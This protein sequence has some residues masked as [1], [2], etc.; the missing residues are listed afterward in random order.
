MTARRASHAGIY[1]ILLKLYPADFRAHYSEQMVQLF[2]DQLRDEGAR[3]SWLTALMDIPSSAAS[4]HLR[5]SRK[6]AHSATLAPTPTSRILGILG[7]IGGLV[8][9][10][11]FV[12]D[13][14]PD[15][16]N[17]RLILFNLGAIGVVL[18]VHRVQSAVSPRLALAGALPALIANALNM[19]PIVRQVTLPGEPL[20]PGFVWIVVAGVMWLT[21]MWFGVITLRLGVVGQIGAIALIVGSFFA[22]IGQDIVGINQEGTLLNAL[23]MTGL[24]I[25]GLG[26]ILLGLDVALRRRPAPVAS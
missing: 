20:V 26:W 18:A 17:F 21:D 11:A 24:A 8:L 22:F 5:R 1:R 4:E 2:S 12:I 19:F 7:V 14:S 3:R 23:I 6:V 25:H 9:L 10:A 13:I 16:N 15:N